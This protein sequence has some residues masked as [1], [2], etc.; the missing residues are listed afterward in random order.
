M[1][2]PAEWTSFGSVTTD[3]A[4][5]P[6]DKLRSKN[7]SIG[8]VSDLLRMRLVVDALLNPPVCLDHAANASMC[9]EEENSAIEAATSRRKE[10]AAANAVARDRSKRT[11]GPNSSA[12]ESLNQVNRSGAANSKK[13]RTGR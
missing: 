11:G 6:I 13:R 7:I 3:N 10:S 2:V 1:Y 9:K 4:V 5:S 12:H 8:S